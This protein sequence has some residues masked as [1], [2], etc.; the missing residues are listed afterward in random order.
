MIQPDYEGGVF[1]QKY[2][3]MY[4]G[5]YNKTYAKSTGRKNASSVARKFTQRLIVQE[6]IRNMARK[7]SIEKEMTINS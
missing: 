7:I 6:V 2:D 1:F 5:R 3:N 4:Q